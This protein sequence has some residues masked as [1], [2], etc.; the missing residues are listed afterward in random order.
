MVQVCFMHSVGQSG[1]SSW[2]VTRILIG[3]TG[4]VEGETVKTHECFTEKRFPCS[5][6]NSTGRWPLK[7]RLV[8]RYPENIPKRFTVERFE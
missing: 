8:R 2:A 3:S 1:L 4:S 6:G 5:G 7:S